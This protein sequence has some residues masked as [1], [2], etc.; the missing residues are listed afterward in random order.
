M[1][2]KL[3]SYHSAKSLSLV[4]I[5]ALLLGL[6][7]E[8]NLVK[9]AYAANPT[10]DQ[11]NRL[12][13]TITVE[14]LIDGKTQLIFDGNTAQWLQLDFAAPG[15]WSGRNEPTLINGKEWFPVWPDVPDAENRF[16]NCTSSTFKGVT[17]VL[18][19]A[20]STVD[21]KVIQGRGEVRIIQMPATDNNYTLILEFDDDP[22]GGAQIYMIELVVR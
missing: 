21:L 16:C 9:T 22:Y 3:N 14:A 18:S 5:T 10:F 12:N 20:D 17:P 8:V 13:R 4:C 19:K 7:M 1:K 15:R 2:Y 11:S 6:I